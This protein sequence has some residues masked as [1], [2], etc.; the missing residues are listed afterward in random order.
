MSYLIGSKV[1]SKKMHPCGS[2]EWQIIRTG[3]DFKLQC[4]GC[5]RIILVDNK[6][7]KKMIKPLNKK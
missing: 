7:L 2:N 6:G 3:A 4:M 1:V 5:N